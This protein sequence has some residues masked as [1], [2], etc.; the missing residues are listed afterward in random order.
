MRY[1]VTGPVGGASHDST[2]PLPTAGCRALSRPGA[3]GAVPEGGWVVGVVVAGGGGATV[4]LVA[5]GGATVVVVAGGGAAVVVVVGGGGGGTVVVDAVPAGAW[6]LR[7][8]LLAVFQWVA[9]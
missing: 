3:E 4:V 9:R 2:M 1:P 6:A 5:G 8:P 7:N